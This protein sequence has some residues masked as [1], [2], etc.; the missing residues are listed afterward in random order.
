MPLLNAFLHRLTGTYLRY[1]TQ[2]I[3][4]AILLSLIAAPALAVP[5][6]S[7]TPTSTALSPMKDNT[8]YQDDTGSKSNGVGEHF[9]AG[10]TNRG[11]LR[12]GVIA[13][14]IAGHIPTGSIITSVTL[15]LNM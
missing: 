12:R 10:R 14:D 3:F 1:G 5:L 4:G 7:A 15:T 11:Q 13:F 6:D 8:L 2:V 9:F